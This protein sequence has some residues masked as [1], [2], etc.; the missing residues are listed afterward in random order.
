MDQFVRQD[1]ADEVRPVPLV[2]A[3]TGHRDLVAS[4]IPGLRRLAR[5]F[6][7]EIQCNC[8]S[9][10]VT[11]LS[12]LA[13]GGGQLVAEEALALGCDLVV[14]LPLPL[15]IYRESL[16]NDL[17]RQGFD[18]LITQAEHF[19][20]PLVKGNTRD[21]I[22][23]P[24]PAR[25]KQYAQ[26]GMYLSGHCHILLAI[27]TGKPSDQLGG[28]AQVVHYH[29]TDLMPGV[30]RGRSR[31]R[32]LISDYESDLVYH[33]VCSRDRPDGEPANGL[34]PL[35]TYYLT[36][37]PDNPRS[38]SIPLTYR[39]MFDRTC[40][41][42]RDAQR[43]RARI[44]GYQTR[45][46][47]QAVD[48]GILG[49]S[50]RIAALFRSADYLARHFQVRV[51]WMLRITYTLA[52]LMGLAFI[53]YADVTGFDFMIYAFLALFLVGLSLYLVARRR[54]WQRKYLD[55]RALAEGL[56]V[57][58]YW[59]VAG[60][61]P[62]TATEFAHDNFLQKQEVELGWIRNAMR[63]VTIGPLRE[64]DSADKRHLDYTIH[65]WI[66]DPEAP[67]DRGQISYY[68]HHNDQKLRLHLVTTRLAIICLWAGIAVTLSLVVFDAWLTDMSR[69]VMMVLMGVLPMAAAVREAY[70]HKKA[71]KELIKQYRFM[72]RLF[73][74]ARAQ[75][76]AA[77][78]DQEKREVLRALGEAALDEHAEWIL[79]HRERPLEHSWL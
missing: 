9:T 29:Q 47:K 76:E 14:P 73:S 49:K 33:I 68:R 78:S 27:W 13:E 67:G 72:Y 57:Q 79:M 50:R 8:Q 32:H 36:V 54:D 26:L 55:Y 44:E 28:T 2:V 53:F 66:G 10:P 56:R 17:A 18:R 1:V 69:T 31:A 59:S 63:A 16:E 19:E 30:A 64:R 42:N 34:K 65:Q 25:D 4:E 45:L 24:G 21:S 23:V 75:L 38:T 5:S 41:F 70:S 71:D 74:N 51:N 11:L 48:S 37:D 77:E 62:R 20:L 3:V 43:Y 58:F 12:P 35:Q 6:L 52:A 46:Y 39:Q 15:D 61:A 40:E 60:V 22:A 7:E